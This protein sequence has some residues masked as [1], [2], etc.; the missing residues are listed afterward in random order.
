MGVDYSG[1]HATPRADL[2]GA[3]MEFIGD[4]D[5][6]IATRALPI[7]PVDEQA[8]NFSAI[9][10]ECL[11]KVVDV[12][13]A[14]R[15]EYNEDGIEA[16]DMQYACEEYGLVGLLDDSE[17][18]K[19]ASDFDVEE[20]TVLATTR[21]ILL[22]QEIRAATLLFNTSTWTG[23]S[24]YTDTSSSAPWT[25]TTSAVKAAIDTARE[26]VRALTGMLPNAMLINHTNF[27]RLKSLDDVIDA[28]KYTAAATD[29][30]IAGMLGAYFGLEG[31]LVGKAVYN[32]AKE[33]KAFASG[34][35]WSN[36]YALLAVIPNDGANLKVPA[37][38]RTCRWNAD[39]PENTVVEQYRVEPKRSE[40]YRVRQNVDELLID[41]S[42]G[43]L[44]KVAA[45]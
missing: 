38:G 33:G 28:V 31:I 14:P 32:S 34:N 35:V 2:G 40:A 22:A 5:E 39:C 43:H 4:N 36:L 21:R 37:V 26:K 6:F 25:T 10:R 15:A 7:L 20:A 11:T 18:R 1:T 12:K 29:A 16:V 23:A 19:Y 45:A 42:F 30:Q 9:T 41:A 13:R 27:I 24:L 17:R 3:V 44:L 8:G